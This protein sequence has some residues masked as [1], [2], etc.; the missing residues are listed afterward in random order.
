MHHSS[1]WRRR[2]GVGGTDSVELC[3]CCCF[4]CFVC[5]CNC[6]RG[7]RRRG[8]GAVVAVLRAYVFV[9]E[10]LMTGPTIR[11]LSDT[12][13]HL[14]LRCEL[15]LR[16]GGT[17]TRPGLSQ[18]TDEILCSIQRVRERKVGYGKKLSPSHTPAPSPQSPRPSY[19]VLPSSFYPIEGQRRVEALHVEVGLARRDAVLRQRGTE[20]LH[21]ERGLRFILRHSHFSRR[22][23]DEK[24]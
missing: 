17:R 5:V 1:G 3:R 7:A 15:G 22:G 18:H 14:S 13:I 19:H 24:E 23:H 12:I 20:V 10:D 2:G 21:H 8:R 4:L 6:C 16:D 11:G 9:C